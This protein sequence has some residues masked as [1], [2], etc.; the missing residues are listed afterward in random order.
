MDKI[1]AVTFSGTQI[2]KELQNEFHN[3]Y[4]ELFYENIPYTINDLRPTKFYRENKEIFSHKKYSGYF[5]WKPY[6]IQ[7]TLYNRP[8]IDA[9]LYFDSNIRFFDINSFLT[10]SKIYLRKDGIFFIKHMPHINKDWTKRDTFILMDAD[11][12]R[13]W[14]AHQVW[15]VILGFGR[16]ELSQDLL[17]EYLNY[18]QDF[19]L[20][21]DEPSELGED[22]PGFREHRW[23]QSVLSIVAESYG[24]DSPWDIDMMRFFRKIYPEKLMEQ[25]KLG[26]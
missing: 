16:S 14:N 11:K 21:S 25:K 19:R 15:S 13:Y 24:I 7:E 2:H 12:E 8:D 17:K 18:C 1:A 10:L 22:L 5:L 4:G 6:I 23:E 3:L 9:V 26:I 20:I